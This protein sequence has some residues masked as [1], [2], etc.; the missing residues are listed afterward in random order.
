MCRVALLLMLP[1][2]EESD[3]LLLSPDST[4]VEPSC[5]VIQPEKQ[6]AGSSTQML[7]LE[8]VESTAPI[9]ETDV[10]SRVPTNHQLE[11][12]ELAKP[13]LEGMTRFRLRRCRFRPGCVYTRRPRCESEHP[14]CGFGATTGAEPG[15]DIGGHGHTSP[16][17][18]EGGGQTAREVVLANFI[19]SVT[20]PVQQPLLP[21]QQHGLVKPQKEKKRPSKP[22]RRSA[23]LAATAW[24]RGDAQ[25]KAKQGKCS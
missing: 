19:Q 10:S 8:T 16:P 6:T 17:S 14:C 15:M 3:S 9:V 5:P 25:S 21:P 23:R 24:P 4:N 20:K 18:P 12:A 1:G 13:T 2:G 22:S 7:R 11:D